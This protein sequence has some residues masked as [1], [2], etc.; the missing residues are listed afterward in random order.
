[1]RS[2]TGGIPIGYKLSAQHIEKDIDAALEIGCDYIIL[3]GRGGATGAA[4]LIFRD[5]ISVPTIP[6][7]GARAPASRQE[8]ARTSR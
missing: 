2:R 3:D 4:P 7:A 5:N 1:M 6:G 8:R